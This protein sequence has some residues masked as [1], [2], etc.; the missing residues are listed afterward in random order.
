METVDAHVARWAGDDPTRRAVAAAIGAMIDSS[1]LLAVRLAR[2]DLPGDPARH[3]GENFGGD[4]QKALDVGA[5]DLFAERLRE[6]GVAMLI[7]EEAPEPIMLDPRGL[8]AVALDPIDGSGNIGIGAPLGTIFSVVP[9]GP[10]TGATG[11]S[12]LAAGY[13]SFG[14][15]IDLGLTLG[16][17]V[18][19]ATLDPVDGRFLVHTTRARL[20]RQTS[21]LAFNASNHRF[22]QPS[23][24]AYVEDCYA[25]KDGPR[26][27]EFNTRWFGAAVGELHRIMRRGGL[28]FYVADAREGYRDGR[29]RLVYEAWPIAFLMEQM[30]GA[31]T[32]GRIAILDI[33]SYSIHQHTPLVFGSAAEVETFGQYLETAGAQGSGQETSQDIRRK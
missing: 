16:D 19:L 11:R 14:H 27:R 24:R 31:A 5:H 23:V 15:S 26:G 18:L 21:D 22:W 13:I 2:G 6:A 33:T 28:F 4:R 8:V 17:G 20:P 10:A 12:Q 30:G 25:G 1:L 3:V 29:L 9:A 7:S 32:D